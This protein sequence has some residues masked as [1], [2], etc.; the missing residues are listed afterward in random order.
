MENKEIKLPSGKVATI[1]EFKGKHIRKAAQIAEGDSGLL[2]FALIAQCT[3][4][5]GQPIVAEQLDE[6]DGRDV[7]KLQTEFSGANF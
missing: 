2:I 5:D 6:M 7:L 4:I 3:L 1:M